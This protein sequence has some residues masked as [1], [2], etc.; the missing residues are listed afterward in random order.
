ML[1]N[2][3]IAF[4]VYGYARGHQE[5]SVRINEDGTYT[6]YVMK[7]YAPDDIDRKELA[8]EQDIIDEFL[9]ASEKLG[10]FEWQSRYLKSPLDG[11]DW[12]LEIDCEA[13]PAF[14]SKGLSDQPREFRDFLSL[15]RPLGL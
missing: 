11:T 15:L 7:K 9:A 6:A 13:H 8:L 2:E 14:K 1:E 3:V 5:L 4:G 10:V 12:S